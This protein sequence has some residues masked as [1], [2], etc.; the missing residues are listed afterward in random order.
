MLDKTN[1]SF[2]KIL[3]NIFGLLAFPNFIFLHMP[4]TM[5]ILMFNINNP[6]LLICDFWNM[7]NVSVK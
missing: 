4:I 3:V 7:L 2:C 1:N 5:K 6:F